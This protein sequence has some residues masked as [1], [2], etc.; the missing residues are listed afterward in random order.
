MFGLLLLLLR[1]VFQSSPTLSNIPRSDRKAEAKRRAREEQTR[2]ARVQAS[3][4]LLSGQRVF[5]H[6]SVAP[7]PARK[8]GL[9]GQLLHPLVQRGK[10]LFYGRQV[11]LHRLLD[12]VGT[13]W[14]RPA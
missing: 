13:E 8:E 10:V 9:I 4:S 12:L 7:G 6:V 2:R 5:V 14:Q 11:L 1:V 3:L